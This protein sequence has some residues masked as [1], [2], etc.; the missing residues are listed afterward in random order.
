MGIKERLMEDMK[1]TL[2]EKNKSR[3]SII[4]LALAALQNK[5]KE[6]LRELSE[7]EIIQVISGLVKKGR[8]S[9]EQFKAGQRDDL[10][11]KEEKEIEIL[12]SFLPKQLTPEELDV[13]ISKALEETGASTT[14]DLG[15]VMKILMSRIAGR[16]EGR[17]V[18]E[19]VR[20]RL[21]G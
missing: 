10:V 21:S 6:F 13:E 18:N 9:I 14:K 16:A 2:K 1:R 5:E 3:L 12:Q 7:E 8:E 17:V 4:R 20:K 19:L 11:T 15:K